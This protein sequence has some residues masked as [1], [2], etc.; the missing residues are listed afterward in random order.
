MPIAPAEADARGTLSVAD[1]HLQNAALAFTAEPPAPGAEPPVGAPAQP[2]GPVVKTTPPTLDIGSLIF[3]PIPQSVHFIAPAVHFIPRPVHF[4]PPLVQMAA[5]LVQIIPPLVQMAAGVVQIIPPVVITL[6]LAAHLVPPDVITAP[7]DVITVPPDVITVPPDVITAPCLI[8]SAC[9]AVL[10]AFALSILSR[11]FNT[12][13]SAQRTAKHAEDSPLGI[14][15]GKK[16][17]T[18]PSPV[19]SAHRGPPRLPQYQ[20]VINRKEISMKTIDR[21]KFE[22]FERVDRFGRD[23]SAPIASHTHVVGLF[24]AVAGAATDMGGKAAAQVSEAGSARGTTETKSSARNH[25][26]EHVERLNRIARATSIS[27]PGVLDQFRMPS[28]DSDQALLAAARAFAIAAVPLQA[29]FIKRGLPTTFPADLQ[30]AIDAFAATIDERNSSLESQVAA[31]ADLE[32]PLE[33]GMK[34]VRELRLIIPEIFHDDPGALAAWA[35]ANHVE[36][37]SPRKQPKPPTPASPSDAS[38]PKA[39]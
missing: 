31:T 25:L 30:Q 28:S 38:N 16:P 5:G 34:A 29:E 21:L 9:F 10:C 23:Y 35:T 1:A 14:I 24:T 18:K 33:A 15:P 36:R 26:Q 20:C 27:M 37:H 7:P 13:Y 4:I 12:K 19:A 39:E 32:E 8:T 6:P 2:T 17:A 3:E 11:T 22:M